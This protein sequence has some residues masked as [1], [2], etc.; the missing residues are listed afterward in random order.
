MLTFQLQ[1][2]KFFINNP[3]ELIFPCKCKVDYHFSPRAAFGCSAANSRLVMA[4]RDAVMKY[5]M[6]SGKVRSKSNPPLDPIDV[7]ISAPDF[8]FRLKGT[9]LNIQFECEDLTQAKGVLETY[10][11][12]FPAILNTYF[13]DP[14]VI[15]KINGKLGKIP[16]IYGHEKTEFVFMLQTQES[17]EQSVVD[18]LEVLKLFSFNRNRRLA[19]ALCYFHT[20]SR[21]IVAGNSDWEFMAEAVLCMSKSLQILFGGDK[22][23]DIRK[24][25]REI[26]YKDDEIEGDYV[27]ILILRNHFDVAHPRLS[28]FKSDQLKV[29]YSYLSRSE[30]NFRKLFHD[31]LELVTKDNFQLPQ[32]NNLQMKTSDQK[33]FDRLIDTMRSRLTTPKINKSA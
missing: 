4:N 11:I 25:L 32:K 5:D 8:K 15:K 30:S 20:S 27:P 28:I 31:I 9:K 1:S 16:F 12:F 26:G 22:M 17:V 21:L 24:G 29:L 18:S 10:G 7:I 14:P 2:R 6:P 23:D 3:E 33:K 13:A 19:A